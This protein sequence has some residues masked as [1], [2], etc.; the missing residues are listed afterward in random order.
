V[1]EAASGCEALEIVRSGDV[2]V[3]LSDWNMPE[4]SGFGLLT[5]LRADGHSLPFG[6]VTSEC[7]PEMRAR[8]IDAGARFMLGKPFSAD[9][10][11]DALGKVLRG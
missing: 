5:A 9:A 6:F 2:D 1:R 11:R 3:I 8:A 10:L 4:M 7:P